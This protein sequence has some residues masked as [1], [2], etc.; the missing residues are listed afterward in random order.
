MQTTVGHR[1]AG[2]HG[3]IQC[4]NH[5]IT[6]NE[7]NEITTDF[8]SEEAGAKSKVVKAQLNSDSYIKEVH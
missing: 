3:L 8:Q 5:A 4:T 6:A 2:R 7:M 1:G